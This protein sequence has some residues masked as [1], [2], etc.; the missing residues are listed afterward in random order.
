M[1]PPQPADDAVYALSRRPGKFYVSRRFEEN[2]ESGPAR[3]MR[4]AYQVFG[5]EGRVVTQSEHGW[6]VVLRET[7]TVR[8][9]L[10]SV[11]RR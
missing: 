8:Q 6:E 4:F 11:F 2:S 3:P 10:S 9:Q 5:A 1:S 7:P